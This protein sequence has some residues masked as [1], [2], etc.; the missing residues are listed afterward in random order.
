MG[1]HHDQQDEP[2]EGL[3]SRPDFPHFSQQPENARA[4]LPESPGPFPGPHSSPAAAGIPRSM[5]DQLKMLSEVSQIA[6]SLQ[7]QIEELN[8]REQALSTQ[9]S[10]LE[11]EERQHRLRVSEFEARLAEREDD[12]DEREK[13]VREKEQSGIQQE[14]QLARREAEQRKAE[15]KLALERD[16][17]QTRLNEELDIEKRKLRESR[18]ACEEELESL[19]RQKEKLQEDHRLKLTDVEKRLREEREEL[20]H[21]LHRDYEE[22][23]TQLDH[24]KQEWQREQE[25]QKA[26]LEEERRVLKLEQAELKAR[27]QSFDGDLAERK[28]VLENRVRFQEDHLE[29]TRQDLEAAQK[30]FRREQQYLRM[31]QEQD[32][33]VLS[34]RTRQLQHFRKVLEGREHSIDRE[35]NLLEQFGF[36][37]KTDL[38]ELR[39]RFERDQ[40]EWERQKSLEETEIRRQQNMLSLHAESVENRRRRLERLQRELEETHRQTLELKLAIEEQWNSLTSEHDSEDLSSRIEGARLAIVSFYKSMR[41]ETQRERDALLQEQ[42]N[43]DEQTQ[44]L[45]E[46]RES[47]SGW[48]TEREELLS[49]RQEELAAIENQIERRESDWKKLRDRWLQER[50]QAEDLIRNLLQQLTEMNDPS[51]TLPKYEPRGHLPNMSPGESEVEQLGGEAA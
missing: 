8:R 2:V 49:A 25:K 1:S 34:L 35:R 51:L 31:T 50:I 43:L 3:D 13:A 47:V 45:E 26:Q 18:I 30:E 39:E 24:Q 4:A 38:H 48:L 16:E 21:Q 44:L 5:Q 36:A 40:E 42:T 22:R 33:T 11:R 17:Y 6:T 29:R 41:Q 7:S 32:Q 9:M 23:V 15:Q 27:Q 19:N 14:T 20:R 10:Q 46:E 37:Q 12:L 28:A